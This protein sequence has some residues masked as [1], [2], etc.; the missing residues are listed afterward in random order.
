ML[1]LVLAVAPTGCGGKSHDSGA[2]SSVSTSDD[3]G[4]GSSVSNSD[5]S[6]TGPSVNT[7]EGS[8]VGGSDSTAARTPSLQRAF[9]DARYYLDRGRRGSKS[10]LLQQLGLHVGESYSEAEALYVVNHVDADWK[11]RAV[12]DARN[13]L[14]GQGHSRESLMWHLTE[15]DGFSKAEATY[16]VSRIGRDWNWNAEAVEAAKETLEAEALSRS[17]LVRRLKRGGFTDAQVRYAV[18]KV[19]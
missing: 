11:A 13:R 10:T 8:G 12:A 5:D 17:Q 9:D 1:L 7:S 19:Y 16:A 2:R 15:A 6:A 3:S 14:E 18:E 4:T